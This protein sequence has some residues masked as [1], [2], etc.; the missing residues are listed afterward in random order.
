M[1]DVLR[2]QE[3]GRRREEIK[4][5]K[6]KRKRVVRERANSVMDLRD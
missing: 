6:E 3:K 4:E 2:L 5:K 1:Y